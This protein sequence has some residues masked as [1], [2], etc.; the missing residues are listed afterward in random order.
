M[1]RKCNYINILIKEIFRTIY[2]RKNIDLP[3]MQSI[4]LLENEYS[5]NEDENVKQNEIETKIT[6]KGKDLKNLIKS[7]S[8]Y[9]KNLSIYIIVLYFIV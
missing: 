3:R 2:N 1:N 7:E 5:P 4:H 9:V 8:E 6:E